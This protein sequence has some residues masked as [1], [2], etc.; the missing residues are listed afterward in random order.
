MIAST[1]IRA[2]L[3]NVFV[4]AQR[5]TRFLPAHDLQRTSLA[6]QSKQSTKGKGR[7][8]STPSS[9]K[10]SSSAK[11]KA[12]PKAQPKKK[13]AK[14]GGKGKKDKPSGTSSTKSS[15]KAGEVS[16]DN[17]DAEEEEHDAEFEWGE[18]EEYVAEEENK[19]RPLLTTPLRLPTILMSVLYMTWTMVNRNR[20]A[21]QWL[22]VNHSWMQHR[23]ST[24]PR[25]RMRL[26]RL[27]RLALRIVR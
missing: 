9:T 13:S 18:D 24:G 4:V 22:L 27:A 14:G 16:F 2:R 21:P 17:D 3:A 19:V 1:S 10:P 23:R 5:D 15:A 12:Q 11:P 25:M 20:W 7:S 26:T 8:T 6:V